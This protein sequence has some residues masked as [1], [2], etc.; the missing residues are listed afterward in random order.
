MQETKNGNLI[1]EA[2]LPSDTIKSYDV[3]LR[4]RIADW[5]ARMAVAEMKL[6]RAEHSDEM[7]FHCKDM[8]ECCEKLRYNESRYSGEWGRGRFPVTVSK[9]YNAVTT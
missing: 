5:R 9:L 1:S 2:K 4:A 3:I 8:Q 6:K 7:I